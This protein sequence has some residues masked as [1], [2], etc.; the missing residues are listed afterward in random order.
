MQNCFIHLLLLQ[1]LLLSLSFGKT[2]PSSSIWNTSQVSQIYGSS[3]SQLGYSVS[4]A[5]DFNADGI[6]DTIIGAP[7]YDDLSSAPGVAF[8]LY[9]QKG[10]IGLNLNPADSLNITQ[11]IKIIGPYYSEFG[12]SVSSAGDFNGDGI[13]DVIIGA[14]WYQ[15]SF[16]GAYI[17]FGKQGGY[18]SDIDLNEGLDPSVGVQINGTASNQLMGHMVKSAGDVNGDNLTDVIISNWYT[19][20][21]LPIAY[22]V[23]GSADSHKEGPID[24]DTLAEASRG[25]QIYSGNPSFEAVN[26]IDSAGDIN[27]DGVDDILIT[28]VYA[29]I[30][31]RDQCGVAYLIYGRKDGNLPDVDLN[32]TMSPNQ[33][34]R[35]IGEGQ[36]DQFGLSASNVGDINGDGIDDLAFGARMANPII[37]YVAGAV[38]VIY[39]RNGNFAGDI[40]LTQFNYTQGFLINGALK[41]GYLGKS[42]SFAGDVNQDGINDIAMIASP[43][44]QDG[45]PGG[46][47]SGG[48]LYVI[49]GEKGTF[50]M[51]IRLALG[52]KPSDGY[53][54]SAPAEAGGFGCSLSSADLN[55]DNIPDVI[56]GAT[57]TNPMSFSFNG[58]AYV[59]YSQSNQTYNIELII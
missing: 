12:V 45:R 50:R 41:T 24:L 40:D 42:V 38:Y 17:I 22:V 21:T 59:I 8:I 43:N 1:A 20:T 18:Q 44:Y 48:T 10:G 37:T 34:F 5:G 55:D 49:Y 32:V 53:A 23:F 28:F 16:G 26:V 56:V 33:G 54:I 25:F 11:G 15:R 6:E 13:D 9:G 3:M 27:N 57:N 51:N 35:I 47:Y 29:E 7:Y 31:G 14:E 58:S 39:G 2:L 30:L 46:K 19:D 52:L 4:S 36:L